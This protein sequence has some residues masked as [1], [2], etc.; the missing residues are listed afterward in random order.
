MGSQRLNCL[1]YDIDVVEEAGVDPDLLDSAPTFADALDTVATETDAIPMTHDM[2]G[3]LT[4]TRLWAAMMLGQEGFDAYMAFI[5]VDGDESA[6]RAMFETPATVLENYINDDAST[7]G[8]IGSNENI[9][10]GDTT[11]IHQGNWAAGAYCT[12]ENF[13]YDE[14]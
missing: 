7:I 8:L 14:D 6:V 1:F 3:I 12:S 10:N 5:N 2:Q 13:D 9:I 4:T 11:F